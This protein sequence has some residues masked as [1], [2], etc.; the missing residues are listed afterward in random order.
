M[1]FNK[2]ENYL[3]SLASKPRAFDNNKNRYVASNNSTRRDEIDGILYNFVDD[4][5]LGRYKVLSDE[6]LKDEMRRSQEMASTII[7]MSDKNRN[8]WSHGTTRQRPASASATFVPPKLGTSNKSRKISTRKL[9]DDMADTFHDDNFQHDHD[10]SEKVRARE[11][12]LISSMTELQLKYKKNLDVIEKLFK[13]KNEAEQH[14][15]EMEKEVKRYRRHSVQSATARTTLRKDKFEMSLPRNDDDDVLLGTSNL[16]GDEAM[17]DE[18]Y[19]SHSNRQSQ[20]HR[21]T[22]PNRSDSPPS[23]HRSD[24]DDADSPPSYHTGSDMTARQAAAMFEREGRPRSSRQHRSDGDDMATDRTSTNGHG[25]G[26]GSGSRSRAASVGG[27]SRRSTVSHALSASMQ[28]DIDKKLQAK[29]AH[30]EEKKR[31]VLELQLFEQEKRERLLRAAKGKEFTGLA[32]RA[33]EVKERHDK[34]ELQRKA[35]EEAQKQQ[36]LEEEA[37]KK[38]AIDDVTRNRHSLASNAVTWEEIMRTQDVAREARIKKR[39][40]DMLYSAA[41]PG[42]LG[43]SVESWKAKTTG[44]GGDP[45]WRSNGPTHDNG[46]KTLAPEEVVERL[47]RQKELWKAKMAKTKEQT[48]ILNKSTTISKEV[49]LMEKRQQEMV[50]KKKEALEARERKAREEE[51]KKQEQE[52]LRTQQLKEINL[53]PRRPT[54]TAEKRAQKVQESIEK[55]QREEE[56][57]RAKQRKALRSAKATATLTMLEIAQNEAIRKEKLG[58]G[59]VELNKIDEVANEKRKNSALDASVRKQDLKQRRNKTLEQRPSLINRQEQTAAAAAAEIAALSK[60]GKAVR[61]T[62]SSGGP[63][64]SGA[65][66]KSLKKDG[67]FNPEEKMKLGAQDD[68]G[69]DDDHDK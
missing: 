7:S 17:P 11:T 50:R 13:E 60:V 2:V 66:K 58:D 45:A 53:P 64:G 39:K 63:R 36:T 24:D 54:I 9:K 33:Q 67:I 37:K 20:S 47:H 44:G 12:E 30:D 65:W 41:Y 59:Y 4:R 62:S 21:L 49:V 52:R 16:G 34:R 69:S 32:D 19:H 55:R 25:N 57:E 48:A 40:E 46:V 68:Y 8:P 28:I 5:E 35:R 31:A 3:Q 38:K 26:N 15:R 43:A 1:N 51:A 14:A 56:V 42:G 23:K 61:G 27:E 18:E 6:E 10:I 22:V 29:L